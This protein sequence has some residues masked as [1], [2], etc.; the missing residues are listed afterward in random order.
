MTA[1][2]TPAS[3]ET[4]A[5]EE[6][7]FVPPLPDEFVRAKHSETGHLAALG[8]E[9]LELGFHPG[10]VEAEGPVPDRPKP[11]VLRKKDP[12]T[13]DSSSANKKEE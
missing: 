4:P 1:D 5:P 11:A 9:A 7:Q 8:R 6:K 3:E 12:K 13:A 10:W 2:E